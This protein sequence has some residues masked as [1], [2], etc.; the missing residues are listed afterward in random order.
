MTTSKGALRAE[1]DGALRWIIIDNEPRLN[2]FTRDMWA[3]VADHIEA[4]ERDPDVRVIV[5]RGAGSKAFSAG[6]DIT[7]FAGNRTGGAAKAYDA[8]NHQAF[9]RV[10]H[11]TKPTIAMVSGY[12]YGGGCEIAI[13]CDFRIAADTAQFSIPAARLGLGYNPRWIA[14][15]L[16]VVSATKAKEML[17][18]ARRYPGAQALT[19]GLVNELHPADHLEAATRRFATEIAANAPLT[20]SAAKAAITA[21]TAGRDSIDMASL[22]AAVDDCFASADYAEGQAAFIAKRQP[23]FKG[24]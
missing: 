11:C 16:G 10:F 13:C 22:D 21:M 12:C 23:V 5:L 18:T 15:M 3:A 8:I 14:P 6:A 17:Y 7:E 19:M 9:M 20:I 24:K 4:A 1:T 2:A